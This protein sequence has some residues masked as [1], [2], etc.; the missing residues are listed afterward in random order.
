MKDI[1]RIHLKDPDGFGDAIMEAVKESL[2]SFPEDEQDAIRDIRTQKLERE[3][4][5]WVECNEY[6]VLEFNRKDKTL[7]V[8]KRE[9]K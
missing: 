7:T 8:V 5:P 3:L 2:V 4:E 1:I 6:I 9:D